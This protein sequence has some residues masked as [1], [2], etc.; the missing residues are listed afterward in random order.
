MSS[1]ASARSRAPGRR[2][3]RSSSAWA[4]RRCSA[5]SPGRP[6][7]APRAW[8]RTTLTPGPETGAWLEFYPA[9]FGTSGLRGQRRPVRPLRLRLRRRDDARERH[10][11]RHTFRDFLGGIKVRIPIGMFIPNVSVAYGQQVVR[12]RADAERHR[13]AQARLSVH[14]A[15]ARGARDSVRP[16]SRWTRR[17]AYLMVLDPGSGADHIRSSRVLSEGDVVWHRRGGVASR[18]G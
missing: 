4:R 8:G 16:R 10:R 13:P 9:A 11:R 14:P 3:R 1:K 7:R 15:G 12:D 2:C 6:T 17:A 18:S 5:S